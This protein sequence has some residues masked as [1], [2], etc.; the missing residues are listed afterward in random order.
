MPDSAAPMRIFLV[1]DTWNETN[2]VAKTLK[3]TTAELKRRGQEVFVCNPSL[4]TTL[5][6]PVY[7]ELRLSLTVPWS[8]S[9]MVDEFRPDAIHIATEGPIG[10]SARLYCGFWDR[11]FTTGFHTRWDNFLSKLLW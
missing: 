9:D 6:N 8:I 5:P 3:A 4:F 11:P 7:P 2:G 1:T 10:L